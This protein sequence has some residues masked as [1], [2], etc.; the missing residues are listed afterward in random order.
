MEKLFQRGDIGLQPFVDEEGSDELFAYTDKLL[1]LNVLIEFYN[2]I[3]DDSEENYESETAIFAITY[4]EERSYTFSLFHSTGVTAPLVLYS[5]ISNAIK[6]IEHSSKDNLL[7]DLEEIPKA[8][9][10]NL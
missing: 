4:D 3:V 2:A 7:D 6:Y 8:E 10:E 5:I 1:D 9:E